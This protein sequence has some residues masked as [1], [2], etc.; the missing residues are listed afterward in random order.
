[1]ESAGEI[2]PEE[3]PTTSYRGAEDRQEE[4]REQVSGAGDPVAGAS[5]ADEPDVPEA[6]R[7]SGGDTEGVPGG[8]ET[9][10]GDLGGG[11]PESGVAPSSQAA[12]EHGGS[13]EAEASGE[14]EEPSANQEA[15]GDE[16]AGNNE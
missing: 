7:A 3:D 11:E 5:T 2:S 6:G 10:P 9:L 13:E 16:A 8:G 15:V 14:L 4:A 12:P 1:V